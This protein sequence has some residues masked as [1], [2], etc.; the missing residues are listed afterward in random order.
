M[1]RFTVAVTTPL[2][3]DRAFEVATDWRGHSRVPFTKVEVT[4]PRRGV[5]ERFVGR[6]GIGPLGFDDPMEVVEWQEPTGGV[7]HCRVVKRGRLL[8]GEATIDVAPTADGSVV[9]WQEDISVRP[10]GLDLLLRPGVRV[11]GPL[12]FGWV[13]RA[14]LRAAE[15]TA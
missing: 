6:T 10:G 1:T 13:L 15:G 11:T 3:P 12:A 7:G 9:R 2:P 14:Q 5:G 4:V 8:G